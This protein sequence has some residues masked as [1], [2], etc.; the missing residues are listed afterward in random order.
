MLSVGYL[1][2]QFDGSSSAVRYL[3]R[4]LAMPGLPG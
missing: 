2:A 1:N 4:N 3:E